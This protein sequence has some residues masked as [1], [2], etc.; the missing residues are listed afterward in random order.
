MGASNCPHCQ[1]LGCCSDDCPSP[2]DGSTRVRCP[3]PRDPRDVRIRDLEAQ[4]A[5]AKEKI[6][7]VQR[8]KRDVET[9]AR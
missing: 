3:N 8:E 1:S 2:T 9:S 6:V 7:E 4:L 5:A